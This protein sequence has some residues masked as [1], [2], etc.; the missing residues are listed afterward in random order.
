MIHS[1]KIKNYLSFKEETTF[2]FVAT[3]DAFAEESQV[4]DMGDSVRLS[5]L[6]IAYGYNA[7]GKSNLLRAFDFLRDFWRDTPKGGAEIIDVIPFKLDKDTPKQNSEF[8]LIFY[9]QK[10]KGRRK[11]YRYRLHI[12]NNSVAL[13]ELY[14][15]Q[16]QR[17]VRIFSRTTQ[18]QLS[19]ILFNDERLKLTENVQEKISLGCLPNTSVFAAKH[20]VNI[21]I[22]D[23]DDARNGFLGRSLPLVQTQTQ[24]TGFGERNCIKDEG[25]REKIISLMREADFN[26]R[27]IHIKSHIKST[28]IPDFL[29]E[30][31]VHDDAIPSELK[32]KLQDGASLNQEIMES[33]A[34]HAVI[35]SEGKEVLYDLGFNPVYQSNGTLKVF[36]LA[37]VIY[38]ALSSDAFLPIDEME[39]ALHQKLF[40]AL[41]YEFLRTEKSEAQLLI[42][43]HNDGLLDLVDDLIRKDSVCFSEKRKDGSTEFYKLTDFRGIES[44]KSIRSAYRAKRFGATMHSVWRESEN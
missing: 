15:M 13:E 30:I 25:L 11:K 21:P 10:V 18:E 31:L 24:L 7:S 32:E 37:T 39:T 23:I 43:T 17:E 8:E 6:A 14:L 41:L 22:S 26:V 38:K 42:T 16:R 3:D 36:G 34:T 33:T 40:E 29:R 35:S 19:Q 9:T 12:N 44:L 5:R 28:E 20:Q 27:S 1:L 2:S 4:V